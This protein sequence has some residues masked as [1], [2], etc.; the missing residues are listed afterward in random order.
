MRFYT[1]F[2]ISCTVYG[3]SYAST[4]DPAM[5]LLVKCVCVDPQLRFLQ[6]APWTYDNHPNLNSCTASPIVQV[7]F[8]PNLTAALQAEPDS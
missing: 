8:Q 3:D 5:A 2:G 7:H 6:Y 1:G 4:C